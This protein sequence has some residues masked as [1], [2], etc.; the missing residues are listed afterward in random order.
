MAG[1]VCRAKCR[2]QPQISTL[3][4]LQEGRRSSDEP[5]RH[6]IAQTWH[7]RAGCGY[8]SDIDSELLEERLFSGNLQE[9]KKRPGGFGKHQADLLPASGGLLHD[10]APRVERPWTMLRQE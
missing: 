9:N 5:E 10:A 8:R 2:D 6:V 7:C 3:G 4:N 1:E